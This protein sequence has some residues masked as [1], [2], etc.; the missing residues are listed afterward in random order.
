MCSGEGVLKFLFSLKTW[1]D[2]PSVTQKDT[3][4][5]GLVPVPVPMLP[6]EQGLDQAWIRINCEKNTLILTNTGK[7][8]RIYAVQNT[9]R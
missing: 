6:L 3:G 2:V 8:K 9:G 5:S 4:R 7:L 1:I